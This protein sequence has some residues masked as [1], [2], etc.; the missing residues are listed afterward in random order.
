MNSKAVQKEIA[1][2]NQQLNANAKRIRRANTEYAAEHVNGGMNIQTKPIGEVVEL[3]TK[4]MAGGLEFTV[5][6]YKARFNGER[7]KFIKKI[8]AVAWL[9]QKREEW[10]TV[11]GERHERKKVGEYVKVVRTRLN[12]LV[13]EKCEALDEEAKSKL[14]NI[15][16]QLDKFVV[17]LCQ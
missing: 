9:Q 13:Q 6:I 8:D 11:N 10:L 7:K 2:H 1:L 15:A 3:K 4:A 12:N 16:S 17:E 14:E 5:T